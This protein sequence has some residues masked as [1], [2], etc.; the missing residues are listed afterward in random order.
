MD[1]IQEQKNE[2]ERK[3]KDFL[4]DYFSITIIHIES[5]DRV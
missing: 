5:A 3:L 4:S 1:G 2:T